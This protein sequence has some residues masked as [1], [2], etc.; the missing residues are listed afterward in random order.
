[1]KNR[2][3][4]TLIE[5]LIAMAIFIFGVTAVLGL[6]QL[7]GGLEARAR[8][9]AELAP[10]IEPLIRTL[11]EETWRQDAQGAWLPPAPPSGDAVPG[12]PDYHYDL[13]VY[14]GSLD[15]PDLVRAQLRFWRTAPDR[16]LAQ[17]SFLLPRRIPV[18]RR[19]Q[20]RP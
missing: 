2:A 1:M 19:L 3:G 12:A 6:F 4:M 18:E 5:V 17:S 11:R 7:G 20:K 10:A 13:I 15:H 8:V 14:P 9:E 16:V